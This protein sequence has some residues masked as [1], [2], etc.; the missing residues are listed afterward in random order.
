MREYVSLQLGWINPLNR[1]QSINR[2]CWSLSCIHIL[3]VERRLSSHPHPQLKQYLHW[4]NVPIHT[5][6]P[7]R[8]IICDKPSPTLSCSGNRLWGQ[9]KS[10]RSAQRCLLSPSPS[11]CNYSCMYHTQ[12]VGGS[13]GLIMV[14]WTLQHMDA[15][16]FDKAMSRIWD[17]C[18]VLESIR[19]QVSGSKRKSERSEVKKTWFPPEKCTHVNS[20]TNCS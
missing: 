13:K 17:Q 18:F 8:L 10:V 9:A 20:T 7:V 6:V 19:K 5:R 16:L 1:N 11:V 12:Q 2:W 14:V 15:G 4:S 3:Y